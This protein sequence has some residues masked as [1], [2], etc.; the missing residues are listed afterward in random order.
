MSDIAGRLTAI[1]RDLAHTW[2]RASVYRT[3]WAL[4]LPLVL[5]VSALLLGWLV[6]VGP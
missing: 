4:P 3:V 5:L 2:L 6:W 1:L